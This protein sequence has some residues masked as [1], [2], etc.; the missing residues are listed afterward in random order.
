MRRPTGG[1]S[2]AYPDESKLSLLEIYTSDSFL[3]I[4]K[5]KNATKKVQL[6]VQFC[7]T[8]CDC[9]LAWNECYFPLGPRLP[10]AILT[11]SILRQVV[12]AAAMIKPLVLSGMEIF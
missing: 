11:S 9:G 6:V 2:N 1:Q 5:Y 12:R 8:H 7:I 4:G 10:V 3:F